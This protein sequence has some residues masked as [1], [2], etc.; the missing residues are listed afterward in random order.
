MQDYKKVASVHKRRL[1][2]QATPPLV[3]Y[4]T[5][6]KLE[7]VCFFGSRR[8][9]PLYSHLLKPASR[10]PI[11]ARR[12]GRF[13]PTSTSCHLESFP[14]DVTLVWKVSGKEQSM[15]S[16]T[17]PF[18][19]LALVRAQFPP[20]LHRHVL[21]HQLAQRRSPLLF[22]PNLCA[23]EL[24]LLPPA[25]EVL[26]SLGALLA[27]ERAQSA[28]V[29]LLRLNRQERV[30]LPVLKDQR[31]S[32]LRG[33]SIA[34]CDLVIAKSTSVQPAPDFLACTFDRSRTAQRQRKPGSRGQA[35]DVVFK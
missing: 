26:R 1:E 28:L 27:H 21:A 35:A 30:L 31:Q 25:R 3:K 5:N 10:T 23:R 32:G 33:D 2:M 9:L 17:Y 19:L 34:C 20:R 6:E 13:F 18:L 14:R 4:P 29:L 11:G 12:L 7:W 15:V 16:K 22:F 24:L 8:W